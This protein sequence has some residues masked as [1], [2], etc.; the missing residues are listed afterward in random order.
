[1]KILHFAD[2]HLGVE[3]YGRLDPET[4]LPTRLLDFLGALDYLV[5]YAIREKVDLVLFAGDAY[6]SR[7]PSQ[8]H[9]REFARRVRRLTEAGIPLFLLVGNHDLPNAIGRAP[10]TEIFDTLGVAR[11]HVANRP[12]MHRIETPGGTV[13]VIALPWLRRAALLGREDTGGLTLEQINQRLSG[14]LSDII[15]SR[16]DALDPALPAVLCAHVWVQGAKLGS[17]H[18]MILGD[19]HTLL[20]SS[21]TPPG[22][23]Y[24]A[25]GHIHR[26]QVVA[27]APPVVYAGSLSRVD[28]GEE[29]EAKGFYLVQIDASKPPGER[30][31][32]PEFHEVPGR[33]FITIRAELS[34]EDADPTQ[35]V[36]DA[37]ARESAALEGAIVRLQVSLPAEIEGEIDDT[38][39]RAALKPAHHF[40]IAREVRREARARLG[41]AAAEEI[42]PLEA[43]G[44]YLNTRSD[45]SPEHKKT[46]LEFAGE[47]IREQ[48]GR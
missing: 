11:V 38:R 5:D 21:L 14:I 23:D 3:R 45:L 19:E 25:L 20:P 10:T 32:N 1:M 27:E 12:G 41:A 7:E 8:T 6:Q 18:S 31:S 9:Q 16:A 36:L 13:Q 35:M 24:V 17:E 37:V 22:V 44:H 39:V 30:A 2:L 42:M 26:R 33:N 28:F 34:N 48:D 4:G 47:L 29:A 43:L 46:L 15:R 40:S